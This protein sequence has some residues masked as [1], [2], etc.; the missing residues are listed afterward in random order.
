MSDEVWITPENKIGDELVPRENLVI[1]VHYRK[2]GNHQQYAIASWWYG[3]ATVRRV[4]ED[5]KVIY[6]DGEW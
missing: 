4:I 2:V 3:N 1:S 5:G 6:S